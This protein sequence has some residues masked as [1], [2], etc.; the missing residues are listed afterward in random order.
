MLIPKLIKIFQR[1]SEGH[2]KK[3]YD[4]MCHYAIKD[5]LYIDD[6]NCLYKQENICGQNL[7]RSR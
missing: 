6:G 5:I 7:G 2:L 3:E 1:K 4:T